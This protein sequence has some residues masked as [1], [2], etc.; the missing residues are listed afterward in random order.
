MHAGLFHGQCA[1]TVRGPNNAAMRWGC[2][3]GACAWM[4]LPVAALAQALPN[5]AIPMG[6]NPSECEIQAAL[7]GTTDPTCP[8]L[9]MRRP[10]VPPPAAAAATAAGPARPGPVTVPPLPGPAA[11]P[12]PELRAAFRVEFDFNSARIRPESR[13]ILDKVAA[14]MANPAAGR[15]RFRVVGHTDAVGGDAAN[16]A[17]SRRRAAGVVEYLATH[18]HIRRD[19]L[20]ASGMGAR[21]LLLPDQPKAA[22]NRRVEI[23]NLGG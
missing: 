22:A 10:A 9:A 14:V 11:M 23:V 7:L 3:F 18:H 1:T 13:A 17:L 15:T 5:P 16:L 2:L 8:P 12:S 19:R 4:I 21:E 6:P 20:E